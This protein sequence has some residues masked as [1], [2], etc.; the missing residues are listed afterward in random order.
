MVFIC[1]I[2]H[3]RAMAQKKLQRF[4]EIREFKNVFEYP[5]NMRGKWA[6]FFTNENPITLELAC[7]KGEY[8]IGLGKMYPHRN[9]IGV[10]LKGNRMWVGAK[11]ALKDNM[12]NVAFIRS[13]I[14]KIDQYF[15]K[16]EIA[17]I[18]ITFPDPQLR[19]SR[20]KKRLTHP[21]FLRLYHM[22]LKDDGNIHLK[23]D[24]PHLYEFTKLV[25]NF[26]G[27]PIKEDYSDV[28]ANK[29][30]G[31]ELRIL[32]HYEQLDIA[33]SKKIHYIKFSLPERPL[34]DNDEKL[35]KLIVEQ[36]AARRGT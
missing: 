1:I 30:V 26:Y 15:L 9:F 10:D 13:Q 21:H 24:S 16:G 11:K 7:G 17:E 35:K 34:H 19:T 31:D 6:T 2:L 3:L 25:L 32:T 36:E 5:I 29:V 14:D 8:A 20:A 33:Q 27:V 4:A 22:I 18:W 23:T 12:H 28:H